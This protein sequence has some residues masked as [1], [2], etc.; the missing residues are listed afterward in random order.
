MTEKAR[1]ANEITE[2]LL[3]G[4]DNQREDSDDALLKLGYAEVP[5]LLF[6]DKRI[7][8]NPEAPGFVDPLLGIIN[9]NARSRHDS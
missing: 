5:E 3:D 4:S 6:T 9:A 1:P 7:V 2:G 8:A